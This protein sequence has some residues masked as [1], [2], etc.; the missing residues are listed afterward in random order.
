MTWLLQ[1]QLQIFHNVIQNAH[2]LN[3]SHKAGGMTTALSQGQKIMEELNQLITSK[4]LSWKDGSNCARRR[5]WVRN[6]GKILR[7]RNEL[8]EARD[9]IIMAICTETL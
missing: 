7:L 5:A 9:A 8:K 3:H 4:L 1:E 6:K 2:N